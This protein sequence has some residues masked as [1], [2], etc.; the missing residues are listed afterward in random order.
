MGRTGYASNITGAYYAARLS[1]LNYLEKIR[2]NAGFTVIR[3]I[4][5]DYWAPLG[6]WV[7]RETVKKAMETE[8]EVF[9]SMEQ[10][11]SRVDILSGMENWKAH[12]KY[13]TNRRLTTLD[14]FAGTS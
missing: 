3:W 4:T 12:T 5:G 2:R 1:I 9:E 7:I 10:L 8:P 13:L 6:V 11:I 14:E